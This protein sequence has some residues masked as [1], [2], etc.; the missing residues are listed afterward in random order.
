MQPPL[1]LPG[2]PTAIHQ[3]PTA[4]RGKKEIEKLEK[5][6]EE[7]ERLLKQQLKEKWVATLLN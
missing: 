6:R 3:V 4:K 1:T 7:Q 5:E 2:T